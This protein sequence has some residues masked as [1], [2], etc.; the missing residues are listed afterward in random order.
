MKKKVQPEDKAP[1]LLDPAFREKICPG[2]KPGCCIEP[3]LPLA[4]NMQHM[5][6]MQ[7]KPKPKP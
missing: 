1:K 3:E 4:Q 2:S 5:Q 7:P 6:H